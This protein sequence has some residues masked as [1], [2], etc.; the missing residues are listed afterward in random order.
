MKLALC[1]LVSF[2]IASESMAA[3]YLGT[4]VYPQ[5]AQKVSEIK[6]LYKGEEYSVEADTVPGLGH[7]QLIE[8][9]NCKELYVLVSE[10]LKLPSDTGFDCFETSGNFPYKLFKLTPDS[11]VKQNEKGV[12]ERLATWKIEELDN[13]QSREIPV[14]TLVFL[15][16]ATFVSGLEAQP[17]KKDDQVAWLPRIVLDS[18]L[19]QERLGEGVVKM[20]CTIMDFKPFHARFQQHVAQVASNCVVS[21]PLNRSIV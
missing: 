4:V 3:R 19:T 7:F 1:M 18:S 11:I 20:L 21:M 5:A 16:P 2:V 10:S 13:T 8:Q 15:L 6:I 12:S 14:N 9:S 17:W